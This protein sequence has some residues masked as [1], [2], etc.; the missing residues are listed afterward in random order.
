MAG[1]PEAGTAPEPA[2]IDSDAIDNLPP[3]D[4]DKLKRGEIEPPRKGKAPE[5][6]D[7]DDVD[8]KSDTVPFKTFD[9]VRHR[10][11]E[12]EAETARERTAREGIER[13]NAVLSQRFTELLQA[14]KPAPEAKEEPAIDLGPDPDEDPVGAVK[15]MREQRAK[16]V[17]ERQQQEA[18]RGQQSQVEQILDKVNNRME[19]AISQNPT[20]LEATNAW[21]QSVSQELTVAG[22]RGKAL[23]DQINRLETQYALYAFQNELPIEDVMVQLATSRGFRPAAK[24]QGEGETPPRDATGKFTAAAAAM[25]KR[26]ATKQ[27]AKSLGGS[28]GPADIGELTPQMIADMPEEEFKAF[29]KKYGENAMRKAFGVSVQ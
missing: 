5:G 23:N 12:A 3:E 8:P 6:D 28:G 4:F 25:D 29:K 2:E 13:Q 18:Q 24:D 26:E 7:E 1:E 9:R 11:K 14:S 16:E 17:T 15:W 10:H 27:A 19:W 22:Y 21:R 20:V